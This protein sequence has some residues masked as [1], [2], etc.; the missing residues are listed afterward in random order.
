MN[1]TVRFLSLAFGLSVAALQMGCACKETDSGTT[2][3]ETKVGL[4]GTTVV[5]EVD[6][7]PGTAIKVTVKGGSTRLGETA[8]T[9]I[10]VK[11]GSGSKLIAKF[12]PLNTATDDTKAA[13]TDEM[14]RLTPTINSAA[15]IITIDVDP[16]S[17]SGAD[18]T[19]RVDLELPAG[20]D[21]GMTANSGTGDID[22]RGVSHSVA[23]NTGL[24]KIV[25]VL[26]GAPAAT[27]TGSF[28]TGQGDIFFE[29]PAASPIVIDAQSGSDGSVATTDLPAGW[30]AD[31]ANTQQHK[32]LT[33]P[34]GT[35]KWNFN[36][37]QFFTADVN[38]TFR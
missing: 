32:L 31:G 26:A 12:T 3:C 19:A 15:G 25:C 4:V 2:Q 38:I 7:A 35:S 9:S 28:I 34:G 37:S 6:W 27:D 17:G 29:V 22:L 14:N 5:K 30:T 1:R 33:G 18:L 16:P 36:S 10:A 24:G 13:K 11:A 8:G 20:F 23:A 21:G